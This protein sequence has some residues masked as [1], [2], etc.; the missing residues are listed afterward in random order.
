[1]IDNMASDSDSIVVGIIE[2]GDTQSIP[3]SF[4]QRCCIN[5]AIPQVLSRDS[6]S[7]AL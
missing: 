1:M 7:A 2:A 6:H 4:L 3:H 5:M